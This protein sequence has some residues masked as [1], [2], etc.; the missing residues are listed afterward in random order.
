MKLKGRVALY[1]NIKS[2]I[3][4]RIL[5]E[6]INTWVINQFSELPCTDQIHKIIYPCFFFFP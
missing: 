2:M 6:R 1:V 3:L 5:L 4:M